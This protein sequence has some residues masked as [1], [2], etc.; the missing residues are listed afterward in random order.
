MIHKRAKELVPHEQRGQIGPYLD[1]K[2]RA[3]EELVE[4]EPAAMAIADD[5]IQF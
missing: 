5:A 3:I 4:S 1:A 2:A